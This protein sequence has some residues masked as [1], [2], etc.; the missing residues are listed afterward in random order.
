MNIE[1]FTIGRTLILLFTLA[2]LLITSKL[3]ALDEILETHLEF[4]PVVQN[5][6]RNDS[7]VNGKEKAVD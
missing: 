2:L 4:V 1:I 3:E 7:G 6:V 5:D